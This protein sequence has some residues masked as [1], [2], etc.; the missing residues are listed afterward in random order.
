[1]LSGGEATVTVEGDGSGGP[2]QECALAAVPK[3][4]ETGA[5]ACVD[6]DG[7]DGATEYAGAVVDSETAED[8]RA[9]RQALSENDAAGFLRG[10][11][12]LLATGATGT[13]VN[14]LR[15]LVVES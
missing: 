1:V 4:P 3:L 11:N 2:N 7:I 13:N 15:V 8:E 10:R 14:D 12:A 6:T 9:V 5:F